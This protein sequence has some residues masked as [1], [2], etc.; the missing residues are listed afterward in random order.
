MNDK[1]DFR[2]LSKKDAED[3]LKAIE[4]AE[5]DET[6]EGECEDLPDSTQLKRTL[7]SIIDTKQRTLL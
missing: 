3:W 7:K 5:S 4:E 1:F 2:K 6:L